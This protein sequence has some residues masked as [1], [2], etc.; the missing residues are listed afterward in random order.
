M[1]VRRGLKG[2]RTLVKRQNV[3]LQLPEVPAKDA[4]NTG[5]RTSARFHPISHHVGRR[6][7]GGCLHSE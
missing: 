2:A 7:W 1:S 5:F 4:Q 6:Q 3:L